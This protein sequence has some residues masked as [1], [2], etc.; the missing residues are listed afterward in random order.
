MA[1]VSDYSSGVYIH[2]WPGGLT[3][4]GLW[5]IRRKGAHRHIV[6]FF[7]SNT[8]KQATQDHLGKGSGVS[9]QVLVAYY[10]HMYREL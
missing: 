5:V 7:K 10:A 6:S 4:D 9:S 2:R 8:V 3:R 1:C